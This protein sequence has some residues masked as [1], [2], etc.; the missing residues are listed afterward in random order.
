V[1]WETLAQ[2]IG[3]ALGEP[4][5]IEQRSSVGGGCINEAWRLRGAQRDC[6][7]KFNSA[8]K[9][10]MFEAEAEGLAAMAEAEAVRVPAPICTGRLDG[11]AFIAMEYLDM[12]AGGGGAA[13]A[14]LGRE[15]AD[16]HRHTRSRFGWHRDN[17]IGATPQPNEENPDW[18]AFWREQRLGYQLRLAQRRG[19]GHRVLD[20]GERLLADLEAFF[21]DYRPEASLLHGDLWSGNYGVTREGAPV[22]FDPAVYFGDREADMAMTELFGSFGRVFYDAYNEAWP[23][24]AGYRVRRTFYNLYHILNHFNLF[25]GGYATQAESMMDTL[26]AEI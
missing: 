6:F 23:L 24:D 3:D 16:M 17:T 19:I 26:L 4:F 1:N 20:K 5:S 8:D 10:D 7:V 25:G 22:I 15:L 21:T 9:L 18:L 14:Q 12:G 13:M 2:H 11:Q